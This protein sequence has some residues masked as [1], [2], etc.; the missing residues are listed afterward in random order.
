M[1]FTKAQIQRIM[2]KPGQ[3]YVPRDRYP[4]AGRIA[5]TLVRKKIFRLEDAAAKAVYDILKRTFDDIRAYG[6]HIADNLG[7]D[8][9]SMDAASITWRRMLLAY[10]EPKLGE[11]AHLM[12]LSGYRFAT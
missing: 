5:E 9:L 10:A 11:A 2:H 3:A 8:V 1:P 12:A 6:Q 4:Y 7:L